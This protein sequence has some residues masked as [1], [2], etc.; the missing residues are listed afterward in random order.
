MADLQPLLPAKIKP[1]IDAITASQNAAAP[2][3][4]NLGGMT[5]AMPGITDQ[6][7]APAISVNPRQ[8]A[9][10]TDPLTNRLSTDNADLYNRT[11][12]IAPTSALGK[13]GHVATNIGNVL[14]NIFDP[15]AMALIHGTQ[16][17]NEIGKS[18][19]AADINA[20]SDLQ[21]QA[22][23][24]AQTEATTAYTQQ[25]PAIEQAKILQKLTSALAPKGI[26]A[27]MNP[28][29][30]IDTED[31]T[32]SQAYK[33]RVSLAAMHDATAQKDAIQTEIQSNHYKPG[34]PEYAEAQR[35]LNQVDQRLHV[36]LAGLGLRAQGLELRKENTQAA[37]YGTDLSGNALPGA[38]QI[39]D[40][41]G[42]TTTVGSK[43]APHAISQQS[44]VGS[45]ND[46]SGSIDHT[47][48]ALKNY[49]SEGG[50]LTDPRVISALNDKSTPTAQWV[51]GLVQS[52][53]SP[54]AIAAV[55]ALRQNHEQAGILR[56]ATGG[57]AS[58]AQAQRILETAPMP[59][60]TNDMALSKIQEQKNVR[61]RLAPGMTGV[62][63]GVAVTGKKGPSSPPSSE[64]EEYVRDSS[65]KLVKKAAK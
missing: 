20:V 7:V 56:K 14:G 26:T 45:F 24:R 4:P 41:A 2:M 17:N 42:N 27:T 6:I 39:T 52:G 44:A 49:F 63:G 32:D 48:S 22:A 11:H 64:V 53:L 35:K 38:A 50:S 9:D 19:D 61:D 13:I 46:L 37:L 28:D 43:N 18:R 25:R 59:G 10:S 8:V 31:D 5:S 15:S 62:A 51:G 23:Q 1:I 21:N 33:D 12:P 16:L 58:E 3:T 30:T 29:G 65:G 54:A 55:T 34:T 60:D 57:T 36:A 40:S 47:E